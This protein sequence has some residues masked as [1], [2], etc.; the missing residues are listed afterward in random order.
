MGMFD[1]YKEQLIAYTWI[2]VTAFSTIILMASIGMSPLTFVIL[3]EILPKKIKNTVTLLSLEI[4]WI[5][6]FVLLSFYPTLTV[7]IGMY[8]CMFMFAT[9]CIIGTVF[10]ITVLP[11]TKGKSYD[12]I[13]R[14]LEK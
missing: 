1:L 9:C 2:P 10:Y 7:V 5:L 12:E 13:I 11:E 3:A 14:I 6:A 4:I 8:N